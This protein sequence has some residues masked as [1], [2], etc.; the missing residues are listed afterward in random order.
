MPATAVR[1]TGK[2]PAVV[3]VPVMDPVAGMMARPAGRPVA[4]QVKVAPGVG[5]V[6]LTAR[7]KA[8]P[9]TLDWSPGLT[10]VT[11]VV[12]VQVKVAEPE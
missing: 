10:T 1:V 8:V 7:A 9:E 4:D 6:A 11:G 12:M 2:T 5:S 3:G